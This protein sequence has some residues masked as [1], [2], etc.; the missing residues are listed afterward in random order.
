MKLIKLTGLLCLGVAAFAQQVQ[1]DYDR[2]VNFT[3]TKPTSGSIT[4]EWSW[5]TSFWIGTSSAL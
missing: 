5:A 4:S 1:F 2:S 3:P